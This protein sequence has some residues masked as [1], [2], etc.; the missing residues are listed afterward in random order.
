[1]SGDGSQNI[2]RK[3][4]HRILRNAVVT[5]VKIAIGKALQKIYLKQVGGA[6]VC[7]LWSLQICLFSKALAVDDA[8]ELPT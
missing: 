6:T 7:K 8:L 5:F 2:R 3:S 1:M 4:Y